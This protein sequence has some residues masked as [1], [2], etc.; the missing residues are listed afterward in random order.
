MKS[1][2]AGLALVLLV[3]GVTEG[4]IISKCELKKKLET[5][6][7]QVIR[8][9]GENMTAND[10]NYRLVCLAST[11]GFNT[12]FVKHI[13]ARPKEPLNIFSIKASAAR[14]PVWSLHGVFQLSNQ[15]A[16]VSGMTP[17]LNTC[18]TSCTAF[19]DDDVTDDIA[20]L[21]T[22]ISSIK[23]KPKN[24]TNLPLVTLST[25]LVKECHSR[26]PSSYYAECS[27]AATPMT[28]TS[29]MSETTV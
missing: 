21:N 2:L 28:E 24:S 23:P 19:T 10:L 6:Q 27:I 7:I 8:A 9:M 3:L 4:R 5:A 25:I 26:V 22:I 15:L 29:P 20:C 1:M 18:N 12:S 14:R 13:P 11:T 16:C 17:S